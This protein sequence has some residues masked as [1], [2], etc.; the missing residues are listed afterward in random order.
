[1]KAVKFFVLAIGMAFLVGGC[2]GGKTKNK[3]A[4]EEAKTGRDRELFRTAMSDIREGHSDAGRI[5]LNT[6]INTYPDSPLVKASK[7]A[8][9]DSFYLEGGSK[10]LAQ[11]E[12]G[13]REFLQFFPDDAL[14]N[15]GI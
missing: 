11:A 6:I 13:Y 15:N 8:M 5:E 9:S 3:V 2:G 1:M 7:L 10:N 4:I 12:A 14:A